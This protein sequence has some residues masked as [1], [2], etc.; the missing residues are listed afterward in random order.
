MANEDGLSVSGEVA[1]GPSVDEIEQ[2]LLATALHGPEAASQLNG[3]SAPVQFASTLLRDHARSLAHYV[4]IG[5]EDPL[6]NPLAGLPDDMRGLI[7][8][9]LAKVRE[10][11]KA[12]TRA[13]KSGATGESLDAKIAAIEPL[14]SVDACIV[15]AA[16]AL[17]RLRDDI[18]SALRQ[19]EADLFR[20]MLTRGRSEGVRFKPFSVPELFTA[21]RYITGLQSA[22]GNFRLKVG[23]PNCAPHFETI[24]KERL[25]GVK[26]PPVEFRES[27]DHIIDAVVDRAIAE[28]K[29]DPEHTVIAVE[30]RSA[31]A[32][33]QAF[34]KRGFKRFIH[35]DANRKES[36][37]DP[38]MH[39]VPDVSILR[40]DDVLV[41]ADPMLATGKSMAQALEALGINP[42]SSRR[43]VSV[44]VISAP[45]GIFHL[46]K[47]FPGV[48]FFTAALDQY[49]NELA[50]ICIGLGDFGDLYFADVVG[51]LLEEFINY[52]KSLGM[53]NNEQEMAALRLRFVE[54]KNR[55]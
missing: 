53:F 16:R 7:L 45:E 15:V 43:V 22:E 35:I 23:V 37:S 46:G 27:A 11:E 25:T 26:V 19:N 3:L 39:S 48:E 52:W 47:K 5:G 9:Y 14:P 13:V 55:V 38:S 2:A 44:S 12:F 33:A 32:M 50:F 54:H 10:H 51:A 34:A 1:A 29:L 17:L 49:L 36:T 41:M 30:W 31:L 24:R 8:M 28:S 18:K 6:L 40:P 42:G 20:T 21:G 4:L